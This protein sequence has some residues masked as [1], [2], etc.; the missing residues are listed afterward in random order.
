VGAAEDAIAVLDAVADHPA[1]AVRAHWRDLLDGA[2][3]GIEI[4]IVRR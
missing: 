4:S 2:F 3:E 1:P